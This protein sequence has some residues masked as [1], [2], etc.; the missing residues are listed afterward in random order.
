MIESAVL[1]ILKCLSTLAL[2][3][4][5]LLV[6][7]SCVGVTDCMIVYVCLS[8][9]FELFNKQPS[10]CPGGDSSDM[11]SSLVGDPLSFLSLSFVFHDDEEGATARCKRMGAAVGLCLRVPAPSPSFFLPSHTHTHTLF[12]VVSD[13]AHL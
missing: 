12:V 4:V 9:R 8:V 6:V 13:F 7:C 1:S 11:A 10:G 5:V 3:V 2:A